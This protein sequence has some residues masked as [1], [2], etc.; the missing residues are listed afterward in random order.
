[1]SKKQRFWQ[2][3]SQN[4]RE[5]ARFFAAFAYFGRLGRLI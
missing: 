5:T 1:M 4:L 2:F 3:I